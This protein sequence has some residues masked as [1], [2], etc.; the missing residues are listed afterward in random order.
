MA[1]PMP[2]VST[3]IA[4]MATT[5]AITTSTHR[6]RP[7]SRGRSDPV[8]PGARSL[9]DWPRCS[10]T[11]RRDRH[12]LLG[13]LRTRDDSGRCCA[14]RRGKS[15]RVS[16]RTRARR[17][18]FGVNSG[19]YAARAAR[20]EAGA[21]VRALRHQRDPM[22][23]GV[24]HDALRAAPP[25]IE[26]VEICTGNPLDHPVLSDGVEARRSSPAGR[27]LADTVRFLQVRL[28]SRATTPSPDESDS[29]RLGLR[30]GTRRA[31]RPRSSQ[32]ATA[33]STVTLPASNYAIPTRPY[34]SRIPA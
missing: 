7:R 26:L 20:T 14:G 1:V 34:A 30:T 12:V 27:S 28:D 31:G 3:V 23:P 33:K 4:T 17:R 5:T 13:R 11:G 6:E 25:E 22:S 10:E 15:A 21:C 8:A 18:A 9:R 29:S 19:S 2:A 16:D 24:R 32:R